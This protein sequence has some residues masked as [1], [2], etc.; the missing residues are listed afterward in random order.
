MLA[1]PLRS[2]GSTMRPLLLASIAIAF[3]HAWSEARLIELAYGFEQHSKARRPPQ[4][5]PTVSLQAM[6]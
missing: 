5:L 3:S 4:F 6:P 1:P 2:T